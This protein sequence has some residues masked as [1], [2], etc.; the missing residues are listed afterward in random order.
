MSNQQIELF[1]F[2]C[3]GRSETKQENTGVASAKRT[4]NHDEIRN[5]TEQRGGIPTIVKGTNGLLRIDFIRGAKSGGRE[6]SLEEIDWERWF[7][8]FDENGLS[9]LFSP[10]KESKF[11]KLVS[12][13]PAEESD[14]ASKPRRASERSDDSD[15]DQTKTIVV[16][17]NNGGWLV[18]IEDDDHRKT[19][20]TKADAVHHA[21]ELA[22]A[23]QPS[24]LIIETAEG[25]EEQRVEYSR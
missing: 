15:A 23:H 10:E 11:F 22:R 25:E 7:Q 5:W 18:E 19:Y 1:H 14:R 20:H 8:L 21:R 13:N 12:A 4:R 24:E 9:F 6:P 17:K 2:S 3:F 16:S